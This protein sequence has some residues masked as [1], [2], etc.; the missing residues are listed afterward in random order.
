MPSSVP[1]SF[2]YAGSQNHL[3]EFSDEATP[4]TKHDDV[5]FF[6]QYETLN[7]DESLQ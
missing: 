1:L 7:G 2:S 3:D 5:R 4:L 6:D